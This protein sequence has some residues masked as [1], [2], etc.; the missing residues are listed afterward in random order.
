MGYY[1]MCELYCSRRER[2]EVISADW[3]NKRLEMEP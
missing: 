1:K 3:N 2:K